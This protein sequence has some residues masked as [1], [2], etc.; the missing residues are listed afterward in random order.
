MSMTVIH[1][2]A[3]A[4]EFALHW[5][6]PVPPEGESDWYV[7][8]ERAPAKRLPS[9]PFHETFHYTFWQLPP[10]LAINHWPAGNCPFSAP[11]DAAPTFAVETF[12]ATYTD[13][14]NEEVVLRSMIQG[15]WAASSFKK[16]NRRA[17]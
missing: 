16:S 9:T 6:T 17:A 8:K 15:W 1:G 4:G 10:E 12:T 7:I 11:P 13:P 3:T 2:D 5:P 14:I